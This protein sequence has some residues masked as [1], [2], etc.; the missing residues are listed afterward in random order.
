[1]HSVGFCISDREQQG[2]VKMSTIIST[3]CSNN[4]RRHSCLSC[5][6]LHS[7]LHRLMICLHKQ[8]W[9]N[10]EEWVGLVGEVEHQ[11]VHNLQRRQNG[12]GV[13]LE[14]SL[15][16]GWQLWRD[17]KRK[18]LYFDQKK[19]VIFRYKKKALLFGWTAMVM[20]RPNAHAG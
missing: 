18:L 9:G 13:V 12:G 11:T 19:A 20:D 14:S 1:M 8:T 15:L 10:S 3:V 17:T 16:F 7:Y 5:I 2:Q 4:G 6:L